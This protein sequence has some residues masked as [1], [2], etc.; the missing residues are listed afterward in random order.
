MNTC[1]EAGVGLCIGCCAVSLALVGC[2]N[3]AAPD[4][5]TE[6][7]IDRT[8][9]DAKE[10]VEQISQKFEEDAERGV[11]DSARRDGGPVLIALLST[12][13]DTL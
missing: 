5:T 10:S 9:Q 3:S 12:L 4:N 2:D 13:L 6:R 11:M 1:S 8:M 7:N